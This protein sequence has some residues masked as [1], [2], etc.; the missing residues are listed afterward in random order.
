MK[1]LPLSRTSKRKLSGKFKAIVDDDV[2]E[3]V[4][5]YNWAMASLGYA[6][7]YKLGYL[8]RYILKAPKKVYVDH[9]NGNPLDNRRENL[10]ICTI[11]QNN[12]NARKHKSR[13]SR[14][15]GVDFH[16]NKWR[17]NVKKKHIGY[18]EK[19]IHAAMVYDIWA[20]EL[21]GEFA[22][23]NFPVLP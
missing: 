21:F 16:N 9:I 10:R 12:Q 23:L 15:K 2:F 4:N 7:N 5:K 19:E 20:K 18:F 17:V 14:Y 11:A 8:H 6:Q 1:E 3:E 13:L 22:K